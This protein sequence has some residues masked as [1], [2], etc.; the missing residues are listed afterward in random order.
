MSTP[1]HKGKYIFFI[2]NTKSGLRAKPSKLRAK[3]QAKLM[4][5]IG[6]KDEIHMISI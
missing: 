1:N 4:G 2:N 6:I 3:L 5:V